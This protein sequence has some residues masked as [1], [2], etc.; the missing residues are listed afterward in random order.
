[1][2]GLKTRATMKSPSSTLRRDVISAYGAS[3]ARIA[4]WV[5]VSAVVYRKLGPDDFAVLALIRSTVGLLGYCAFGIGPAI[6]SRL[7]RADAV[8]TVDT[9][10]EDGAPVQVLPYESRAT[11]ANS[12]AICS[13]GLFAVYALAL[14]GLVLATVYSLRIDHIHILPSSV[15]RLDA[16]FLAFMTAAG[17]LIRIVSDVP[18]AALQAR[19]RIALDNLLLLIADVLW[20]AGSA[21]FVITQ[22]FLP[23][24]GVALCM[25]N[26]ALMM[27]RFVFSASDKISMRW[28]LFRPDIALDLLAFGSMVV[29][30]QLADYL[31]APTDNILINRLLHPVDVATYAPAVQ[32]DAGL[33]LLVSGLA[34]V[35]LPRAA[36]AHAN[37][38]RQLLLRYYIRGTLFSVAV[39]LLGSAV[40]W[41]SSPWIFSLWFRNPMPATQAILPLMLVHTIVGGSSAV[42]RSILLGMGKVK[43]FTVAVLIAGVS[44]VVLS[45]LFVAKF[46]LGLRGIVLG[47]ICAVVGRCAIWMPWYVLRSLT[48]SRSSLRP[49]SGQTPP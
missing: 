6:I 42:G 38:N 34:A 41:L 13:N 33:L 39:L 14:L 29:L 36:I 19:G 27:L 1:M 49:T 22:R 24:V 48:S 18:G 20:A 12:D 37:E 45:W 32:I 30:A 23:G 28:S 46:D 21:F 10:V 44:N 15:H 40:V 25:G 31:Y 11:P 7:T 2:H 9:G 4:S 3:G 8:T 26:F 16:G 5:V 35:I 43:P 17:I 47:T